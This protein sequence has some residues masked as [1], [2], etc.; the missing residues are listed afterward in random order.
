[1]N[2]F[3]PPT[4]DVD[5]AAPARRKPAAFF[6]LGL[7]VLQLLWLLYWMGAYLEFLRTGMTSLL[8]GLS[9][10]LGCVLL[11]VGAAWFATNA[12]RG[13]RL[14]VAALVCLA[15]A[16]QA[17]AAAGY[18]GATPYYFWGPYAFGAALAGA[19]VWLCRA[20]AAAARPR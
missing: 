16:A 13:K 3:A 14:F 10:F 20:Q 7:S 9:G 17:W 12:A 8:A 5:M 2:P 11:Y 18:R 4:A 1:M 6:V 15:W 19:G